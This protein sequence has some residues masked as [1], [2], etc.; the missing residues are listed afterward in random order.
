MGN[1]NNFYPLAHGKKNRLFLI[2]HVFV[3]YEKL[4]M[5]LIESE[6]WKRHLVWAIYTKFGK[7]LQSGEDNKEDEIEN[8]KR[9][10]EPGKN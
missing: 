7:I 6:D 5:K 8:G 4:K 3:P 9:F 2:Y 10:T 1:E